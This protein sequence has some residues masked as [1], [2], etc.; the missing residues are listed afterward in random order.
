MCNAN[1]LSGVLLL[2]KTHIFLCWKKSNGFQYSCVTLCSFFI[3][4]AILV[5]L[6][7]VDRNRKNHIAVKNTLTNNCNTMLNPT[8]KV[9][10][11]S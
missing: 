6:V 1:I 11:L 9:V 2:N 4:F 10:Q 8:K 5:H 7:M 3:I